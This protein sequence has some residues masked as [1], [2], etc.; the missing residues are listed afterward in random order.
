METNMK[1]TSEGNEDTVPFLKPL[2]LFRSKEL[3]TICAPMV[4]YSKLAF[5]SLVRKYGCDLCF[6]PMI[7]TDSFLQS[8]RA[9]HSDFTTSKNDRPLIV[10]FAARSGEDWAKASSMISPYCDG[11]DLNCG[12]PQ[13]W[14]MAEGYGACLIHKP[15]LVADMI[16]Q[17]RSAIVDPDFT[18]SIKIRIHKD[19]KHTVDFAR[20]M[21]AAG[22]S[23]ITVHGRTQDQ[24]SDPVCL[25]A[26]AD[27]KNAVK[28][29][30]VANGDVRSLDNADRIQ[31]ITGVDGVMA[32][33]GILEN[34][35]MYAGYES[36][37]LECVKDFV[38][39]AL[40][41]GT[42]FSC[43]HHH[44]IYMLEKSL[45]RSERRYFNVLGSTSGV[46][47]YL[48]EKYMMEFY[49]HRRFLALNPSDCG[50]GVGSCSR[51][52]IPSH[53]RTL[54]H[55]NMSDTNASNGM[56]GNG[57]NPRD[58]VQDPAT[59][60]ESDVKETK[61]EPVEGSRD[62]QEESGGVAEA[63][64][65][66]KVKEEHNKE[67]S[68]SLKE[69]QES[70]T[71][72]TEPVSCD[73]DPKKEGTEP[74][75]EK[76]E[77]K[78]TPS[79]AKVTEPEEGKT[80]ENVPKKSKNQIK[81]EKRRALWNQNKEIVNMAA[82]LL[83]VCATEEQRSVIPFLWNPQAFSAVR[84]QR[85]TAWKLDPYNVAIIRSPPQAAPK[86]PAKRPESPPVII[87]SAFLSSDANEPPLL[88]P[89]FCVFPA[90]SAPSGIRLSFPCGREGRRMAVPPGAVRSF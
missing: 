19:Y 90:A 53:F 39:I 12:C 60:V 38:N 85:S 50:I 46:I 66:C 31:K 34:P 27:I 84:G 68:T 35:A 83:A 80:P 36:T 6:T 3:V 82:A 65:R 75:K 71:G 30:V 72:V 22:A 63:M 77:A 15:E 69:T 23:F 2:E 14:A 26:I 89:I 25:E 48:N 8:V 79:E 13:R 4:R 21:E 62:Q 41:T 86:P 5:R 70:S 10:Q 76:S 73:T 29:P 45:S 55:F 54:V 57:E 20:Q 7:I 28:I 24:R 40:S 58:A 49:K 11:V 56:E 61:D 74:V 67:T 42:S 37:P 1:N 32:A 44:L 43:F 78:E 52:R 59:A 18:V 9:R 88:L 17:T 51:K 81:K 87:F 33:R 47:N 64:E 16:R